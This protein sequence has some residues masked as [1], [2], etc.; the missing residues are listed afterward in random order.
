MAAVLVRCKPQKDNY[1]HHEMCDGDERMWNISRPVCGH[2]VEDIS[3]IFI[4]NFSNWY[5]QHNSN[6]AQK[7]F[8]RVNHWVSRQRCVST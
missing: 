1:E 3:V 2:L 7:Y 4:K 5:T 6:S 8:S